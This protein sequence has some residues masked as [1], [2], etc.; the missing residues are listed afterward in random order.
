MPVQQ[1]R[2]PVH[3]HV[4]HAGRQSGAMFLGR[5]VL[6]RVRIEHD[7]IG[8]VAGSEESAVSQPEPRRGSGRETLDRLLQ[9]P[10]PVPVD[11]GA[12]IAGKTTVAA[13]GGGCRNLGSLEGGDI[14]M[15]VSAA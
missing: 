9:R 5:M 8:G 1:N 15:K 10:G 11:M 6:D 14:S 7:H 2:P 12:E 3:Q 13:G 4:D